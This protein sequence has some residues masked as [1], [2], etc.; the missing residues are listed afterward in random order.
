MDW[1]QIPPEDYAAVLPNYLESLAQ[2]LYRANEARRKLVATPEQWLARQTELRG[3][4][5][6][7]LGG[8]PPRT[9]LNARIVGTLEGRAYSIDRLILESR[10]NFL[11]TANLYRPREIGDPVP[12]ILVPCGHSAN[13]KAAA[14]YQEVGI[15]LALN[16]MIALIYDPV[17]QGERV[18]YYDPAIGD[19]RVGPCT[20]EHS[21]MDNQC[22]LIGANIAQYRIWDGIRCL[23]YLETRPEVDPERLGCTG[24]S[25]G[26]TLTAYI[27]ALDTRVKAA[28]PVCYLTSREAQQATGGIAD[29][30]QNLFGC[31]QVGLDEHEL[32][33]M[34]A[35]RALRIG[36]AVEDFFPIE[37]TREIAGFCRQ[38]WGLFGLDGHFDL[39]EGP[40]GHGYSD[41]IREA[42]VEW[43]GRIFDLPT[44]PTPTAGLV[45]PDDEL[46]CT[47]S[48]QIVVDTD[49]RRVFEVNV[50]AF[51]R[52]APELTQPL[53][54]GEASEK[55]GT[56]LGLDGCPGLPEAHA[57]DMAGPGI[58]LAAGIA[59][60]ALGTAPGLYA[61]LYRPAQ[62]VGGAVRL[63]LSDISEVV[64]RLHFAASA[65]VEDP[66]GV[67]TER[68]LDLI[69]R[70]AVEY[71]E[72]TELPPEVLRREATIALLRAAGSPAAAA[73]DDFSDYALP[74]IDEALTEAICEAERIAQNGETDGAAA[75][76]SVC[77]TGIFDLRRHGAKSF[78]HGTG[79]A[80][81]LLGREAFAA[82]YARLMGFNL[83]RLR[84]AD[85]C[86]AVAHLR[87]RC[88]YDRVT[89][90]ARGRCGVW[91]LHAGVLCDGVDALRLRN[92]PWSFE[93]TLRDGEYTSPHMAD[94]PRG[95]LLHYDLPQLCAALAPRPLQIA[96]PLDSR[97][98]PLDATY[99]PHIAVL[100]E[101]YAGYP[102]NLKIG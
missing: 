86:A 23:D 82:Y 29:G 31:L 40:G 43:F 77:G 22:D 62:P 64:T 81:R 61:A 78:E 18:Q 33:A 70:T 56:V 13:G 63:L 30:E 66:G 20:S 50:E 11:L 68:N 99:Q 72:R 6:E 38:V 94:M 47:A 3:A 98:E 48:G 45:R 28:V 5:V 60:E 27:S 35:P 8:F 39:F 73:T 2:P 46:Y 12:G 52:L 4:F 24:C 19:S 37:G 75:L 42:A 15:A 96:T 71:E 58:E 92:T 32:A 51:E 76:L 9:P 1:D 79:N 93:Q 65:P 89:L 101:A 102:G 84:V 69:A 36:A 26:G 100:R 53:T 87:E 85:I 44:R 95:V 88:G 59:S 55:I 17:S 91:A 21:Q 25:G 34:V 16:G 97:G 74:W 67:L 14:K 41:Q 57:I 49:T 80:P 54:R 90:D 7:A 83:M 10:P